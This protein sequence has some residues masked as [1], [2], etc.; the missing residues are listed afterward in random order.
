VV[1]A[2]HDAGLVSVEQEKKLSAYAFYNESSLPPCKPFS[3]RNTQKKK[4]EAEPAESRLRALR[5]FLA[6]VFPFRNR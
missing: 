5:K 1:D 2:R 6:A 3:T 4:K